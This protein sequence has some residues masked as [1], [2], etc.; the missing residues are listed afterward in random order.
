[1]KQ[2]N[3]P[4]ELTLLIRKRRS[5]QLNHP[6]PSVLKF[7]DILDELQIKY[8]REASLI[9][10]KKKMKDRPNRAR[11]FLADFYL[12]WPYDL[13]IEIDGGVH[14]NRIEYDIERDSRL[15]SAGKLV[16]R[17]TNEEIGTSAFLERFKIL[18]K[19]RYSK[20]N[21]L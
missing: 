20:N 15:L 12:F 14:N 5:Y 17:F 4:T 8:K 10:G 9:P 2:D 13:Y 6:T 3:Q 16:I 7:V 18:L 11:F 19:Q 1:M 21:K